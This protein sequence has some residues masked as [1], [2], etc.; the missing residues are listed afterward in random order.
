MKRSWI[1]LAAAAALLGCGQD[2]AY[3][4]AAI[5]I[6]QAHRDPPDRNKTSSSD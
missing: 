4:P 1:L 6:H 2:V 5:P 3:R